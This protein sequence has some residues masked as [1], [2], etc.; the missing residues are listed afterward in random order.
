MAWRIGEELNDGRLCAPA[1]ERNREA[2]LD[3]LRRVLPERGLVLEIGS[4]TGQH[5]AHFAK[6]L[7]R[8]EWQPSDPD[9]EYRRS[10][11]RWIGHEQL[12]NVRAPMALDVRAESW[13]IA[14]ADA[15]VC[16]NVVHVSPWDA[17]LALL[18]GAGRVLAQGGVLYLY[19]PYRRRGRLT[20]PSNEKFD[21]ELHAHDPAWGLREVESVAD[22]AKQESLELSETVE[23]PANNLSLVFARR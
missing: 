17:T 15:I 2:I 3:V 11:A 16:I 22:A 8:L 23:M 7:P 20:A 21:A 10:I 5:V 6:A 19:G 1:A 9:P 18:S 14:A 13:P 12:G 4:G